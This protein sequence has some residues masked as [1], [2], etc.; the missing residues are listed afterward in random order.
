[1]AHKMCLSL[2]IIH[3]TADNYPIFLLYVSNIQKLVNNKE[4]KIIINFTN[5][6]ND[7]YD[8]LNTRTYDPANL[9]YSYGENKVLT[10]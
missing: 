7:H 2:I 1:M 6:T 8:S 10:K 3:I 5:Y 9:A 4:D